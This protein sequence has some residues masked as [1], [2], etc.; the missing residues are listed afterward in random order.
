MDTDETVDLPIFPTATLQVPGR[1]SSSP[2]PIAHSA[3]ERASKPRSTREEAPAFSKTTAGPFVHDPYPPGGETLAYDRRLPRGSPIPPDHRADTPAE[4]EHYLDPMKYARNALTPSRD[5]SSQ[6]NAH[7][8]DARRARLQSASAPP[9][10]SDDS[11]ELWR[12]TNKLAV[13]LMEGQTN[14]MN[15]SL[16]TT[17]IFVS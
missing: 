6:V 17:L 10:Y 7:Q 5:S 4:K 14:A 1:A 15:G 8:V 11:S 16:D 12:V 3:R 13:S 2:P 9:R